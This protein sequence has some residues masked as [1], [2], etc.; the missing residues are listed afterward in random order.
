[1]LVDIDLGAD[2]IPQVPRSRPLFKSSPHVINDP[3]FKNKLAASVPVW[4]QSRDLGMDILEWWD[5]VFKLRLKLLMIEHTKSMARERRG[6]LNMLY[7]RLS[8]VTRKLQASKLLPDLLEYQEA[9]MRIDN[10]FKEENKAT[11][12]KSKCQEID[13]S[14]TTTIFHHQIHKNNIKHSA[15]INSL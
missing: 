12:L 8:H 10:Y 6:R 15:V 3:M 9:K 2:V 14:E 13:E 4:K 1:M 5:E 7:L 11:L